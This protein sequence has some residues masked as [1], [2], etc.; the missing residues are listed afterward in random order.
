[1]LKYPDPGDM[2]VGTVMVLF[3]ALGSLPDPLLLSAP[4]RGCKGWALSGAGITLV[5]V[6]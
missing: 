2:G 3:P 4:L 5:H 6:L 1:M